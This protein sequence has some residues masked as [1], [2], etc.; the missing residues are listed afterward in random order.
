MAKC[1]K[2]NKLLL[3]L[4]VITI[5]LSNSTV[6]YAK[7]IYLDNSFWNSIQCS[8]KAITETHYG[9]PIKII[10]NC[11]SSK[12]GRIGVYVD[13]GK[14]PF[15]ESLESLHPKISY[16]I[17]NNEQDVSAILSYDSTIQSNDKC[18]I[19]DY[20]IN[21]AT[22][23]NSYKLLSFVKTNALDKD[24]YLSI[25]LTIDNCRYKIFDKVKL[26]DYLSDEP[27]ETI[28]NNSDENYNITT[29][30][31]ELEESTK[32]KCKESSS[33]KSKNANQKSH[34]KKGNY[35]NSSSNN[36]KY[37]NSDY[38]N[39]NSPSPDISNNETESSQ[40][41]NSTNNISE[42]NDNNSKLSNASKIALFSGAVIAIIG[43]TILVT[44]MIFYNNSKKSD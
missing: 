31:N 37:S 39:Y 36:Y 29:K 26:Y 28:S 20:G 18:S 22:Y 41:M 4:I 13:I 27:S 7:D 34:T 12:N 5:L 42:F 44:S 40:E 11:S 14:S 23:N 9:N 35:N 1:K 24:S 3:Y 10:Y 2:Y 19:K 21:F 15:I 32:D 38:N 33:T 43:L 8:E 30:K 17:H 25:Y 6:C 16:Y